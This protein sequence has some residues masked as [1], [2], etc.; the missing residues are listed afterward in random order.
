MI[1][2]LI[3]CSIFLPSICLKNISPKLC[4]NCKYYTND[5]NNSVHGKCSYFPKEDNRIEFLVNGIYNNEYY[6]CSNARR[7]QN[8]CGIEGKYYKFFK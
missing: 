6:F 8:M 7:D 4:I 1:Y 5:N 2:I 3:F